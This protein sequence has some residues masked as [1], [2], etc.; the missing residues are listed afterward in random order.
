MCF[1]ILVVH[2]GSLKK[3]AL[4]SGAL[5]KMDSPSTFS[6]LRNN[7]SHGLSTP[8]LDDHSLQ[9]ETREAGMFGVIAALSFLLN[10][11]F[12][13]IMMKKPAMLKRPHNILLFSLAI[14]D[15]LTGS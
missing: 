3:T 15:L 10:S 1:A 11:L 7:S 2:F 12:C 4:N 13:V 14:T 5:S 6:P 8:A 9:G